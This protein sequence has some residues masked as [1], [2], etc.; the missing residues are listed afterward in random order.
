MFFVTNKKFV[1]KDPNY[2]IKNIIAS[3]IKENFSKCL[4]FFFYDYLWL[5]MII[6]LFIIMKYL[7][8]NLEQIQSLFWIKKWNRVQ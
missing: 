2:C 3:I 7:S 4:F 6:Y 5:F 1:I 8:E